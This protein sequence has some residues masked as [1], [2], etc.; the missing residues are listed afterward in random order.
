MKFN[1]VCDCGKRV[2]FQV[3]ASIVKSFKFD[4]DK[5]CDCRKGNVFEVVREVRVRKL[6]YN[7]SSE[8]KWRRGRRGSGCIA[9]SQRF[10]KGNY[11]PG[12]SHGVVPNGSYKGSK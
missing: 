3:D 4:V 12:L 11:N 2:D 5:I 9:H 7:K 6:S 1:I 10:D 8:R